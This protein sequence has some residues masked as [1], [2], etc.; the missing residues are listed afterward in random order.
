MT[1]DFL[2]GDSLYQDVITYVQFGEHRTATQGEDQ[3]TDWMAERLKACGLN[4]GFQSFPV[5]TFFVHES[6]LNIDGKLV[7]C[8]PLWPPHWTGPQSVRAR[9][10]LLEAEGSQQKASMA[11]IKPSFSYGALA[12]S[13][14]E[15]DDTVIRAAAERGAVAALVISNGPSEGIHAYNT[16]DGT[17][18]WP[19]PVALVP[20]RNEPALTL[21]AEQRVEASLLLKGSDE[22]QVEA[23]NIVARLDRG[24]DLIVISTPKSGWFSCAGERGPGIALFLALAQWASQRDSNVSYIFEANTG[25]ETGGSGIRRFVEDLAPAPESVLAWIHLGANIATWEWEE[26]D[27]GL[28]KRARPDSYRVV[29]SNQELLPLLNTALSCLPG[30]EPRVGRGLGEMRLVIQTGYRGFG[31]NGGP[32]RYFHTPEDKPDV[33]TGPELLESVATALTTALDLLEAGGKPRK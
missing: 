7:Q 23:K 16:P 20:K 22:L 9:L 8:F 18:R 13:Q 17:E 19:I 27:S 25:H 26:T 31:V 32:Y 33:A 3:T 28:V 12:Y 1:E 24:G 6:S 4:V 5:D 2:S 11:L 29:C 30:L 21:A 10:S 15:G 14:D